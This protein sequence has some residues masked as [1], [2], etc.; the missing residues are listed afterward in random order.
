[1]THKLLVA[2]FVAAL[3]NGAAADRPDPNA[4]GMDPALLARIPQ[5]MQAFVDAGK[6]AGIVT[7]VA[8]HGHLASVDAVGYQTLETHTPMTTS[9]IFR[10]ASL[11][12]PITCAGVMTLV[13]EGRLSVIDPVEKFLPEFKGQKVNGCGT[14]SGINCAAVIPSRPISI[15]DL[16]THTSGLPA[17]SPPAHGAPANSLADLVTA[18]ARSTLLFP[19]GTAWNYSNL[20]YMILGRI[21]ELVSGKPYDQYMAEKIFEPLRMNDTEFFVPVDKQ[22]RVAA[23]YTEEG[24]SLKRAAGVE[25]QN[26]PRI[27]MPQGGLF[28]TA[29]DLLRFNQMLLNKGKFDGKR[30]LSAGAVELMT[31]DLT[32]DIKAGFSPGVGHGF[33][34]EVVR[35]PKG[36][37][38]YNSIGSFIKGGAYR[39]YMSVDPAKDLI[40]IILLQRT[41]GGGDVADEINAFMAMA[42]ASIDR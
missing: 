15:L 41:N 12:K 33:G 38:R 35:E 32:G 40:E 31:S 1:M 18:G 13:D 24:G 36:T 23:V 28:S 6:A 37:F 7:L 10:I 25:S 4:A 8:R 14:G 34:Y 3:V 22:A 2:L 26:G 17:T 39:T 21:I 42:A 27:P 5:R 19:P 30:V 29:G 20:G 11:T 9:S 16:M